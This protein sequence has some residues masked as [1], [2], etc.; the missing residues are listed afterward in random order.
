MR[1]IL[2]D[3]PISPKTVEHI[4]KLGIDCKHLT[5]F[6]MEKAADKEIIEFAKENDYTILTEDLDFG[7]ILFYTQEIEPCVIIL[8][9]GNLNTTEINKLIEKTLGQILAE[10]N[11][12]IIVERT[13]IRIKK[14]PIERKEDY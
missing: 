9:V 13:R 4:R 1:K 7:T 6:R 10:E 14:L 3:M 11:S 5:E 2:A 8:R 12:I